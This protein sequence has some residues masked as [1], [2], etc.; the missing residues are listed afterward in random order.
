MG[1]KFVVG[2]GLRTLGDIH[3]EQ[4]TLSGTSDKIVI[5]SASSLEPA[6]YSPTA[7]ITLNADGGVW[8]GPSCEDHFT[9]TFTTNGSEVMFTFNKNKFRGVK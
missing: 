7:S 8:Y 3:L 9:H 4:N 1:K 6:N 5:S 2:N